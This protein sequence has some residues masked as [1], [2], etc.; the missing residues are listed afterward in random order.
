[1][2]VKRPLFFAWV[3]IK[4]RGHS[5]RNVTEYSPQWALSLGGVFVIATCPTYEQ[6]PRNVRHNIWSQ[7][8]YYRKYCEDMF[9][10]CLQTQGNSLRRLYLAQDMLSYC[11]IVHTRAQQYIVFC[12]FSSSPVA[13]YEFSYTFP[14]RKLSI[15]ENKTERG[16]RGECPQCRTLSLFFSYW[17]DETSDRWS[18][19]RRIRG[20]SDLHKFTIFT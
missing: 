6:V 12:S 16:L 13:T 5:Q 20:W 1:M 18:R 3:R 19:V 2:Q 15:E 14:A 10:P 4:L 8:P 7:R 11:T 9:F 17:F